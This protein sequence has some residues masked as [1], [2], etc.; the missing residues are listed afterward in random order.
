MIKFVNEYKTDPTP[1]PLIDEVLED[2]LMEK[3]ANY[4]III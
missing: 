4:S 3:T 1:T 2:L